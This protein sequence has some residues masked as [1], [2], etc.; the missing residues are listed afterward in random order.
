MRAAGAGACSPLFS[1]CC[2]PWRPSCP[3]VG[4]HCSVADNHT[5]QHLPSG[6]A[7]APSVYCCVPGHLPIQYLI[8][9]T[10][11]HQMYVASPTAPA[12]WRCCASLRASLCSWAAACMS[13]SSAAMRWSRTSTVACS[14]FIL[15][16]T[17]SN[18]EEASAALL[19]APL[20][21]APAAGERSYKLQATLTRCVSVS[22][23]GA[24]GGRRVQKRAVTC[25]AT[26]NA[27]DASAA[28]LS[29]L[30]I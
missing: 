3:A 10:S 27:Q 30:M 20:T 2:P 12:F 15:L 18:T 5:L 1:R 19:S 7:A 13:A 17:P 26:S 8:L 28:L 6:A 14:C 21:G 24:P 23:S 9:D 22:L 11:A 16:R 4:T 29:A 25:F